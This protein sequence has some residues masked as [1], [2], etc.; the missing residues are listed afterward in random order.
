MLAQFVFNTTLDSKRAVYLAIEAHNR[1]YLYFTLVDAAPTLPRITDSV[2]AFGKTVADIVGKQ[3]RRGALKARGAGPG[4]ADDARD[5]VR[6]EQSE[7]DRWVELD[8][9]CDVDAEHSRSRFQGVRAGADRANPR[10]GGRRAVE[11]A[12]RGANPDRRPVRRQGAKGRN[13]PIEAIRQPAH[14]AHIRPQSKLDR[15]RGSGDRR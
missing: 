10:A 15:R 5:R 14:A 4:T 11:C 6:R 3:L 1:A 13:A 2:D 12:D 7:R 8:R 9:L